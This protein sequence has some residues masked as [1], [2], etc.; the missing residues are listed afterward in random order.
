MIF[1]KSEK[2]F[3]KSEEIFFNIFKKLKIVIKICH[4]KLSKKIVTKN[5]HQKLSSKNVIKNCHQKL[6]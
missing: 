1:K 5:C 3:Q 6:S 4:Q 2:K